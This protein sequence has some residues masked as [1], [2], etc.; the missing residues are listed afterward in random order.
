MKIRGTRRH[1]LCLTNFFSSSDIIYRDTAHY[2]TVFV[3]I[4][5]QNITFFLLQKWDLN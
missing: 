4:K 2:L 5:N 3:V 1:N